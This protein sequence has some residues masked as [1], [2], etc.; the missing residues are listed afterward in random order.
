MIAGHL[1]ITLL[2]SA[3]STTTFSLIVPILV[4]LCTLERAVALIQAY[5]FSILR[6][7]YIEEVNST[8][9]NF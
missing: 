6:I 5:V 8:N 9:I 2:S 7:L 3:S 4:I 1:L